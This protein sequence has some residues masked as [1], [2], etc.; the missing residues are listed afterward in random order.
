MVDWFN[1]IIIHYLLLFYPFLYLR[2]N[3]S[4]SILT[5]FT[6][7]NGILKRKNLK[8]P[9]K[10]YFK[11]LILIFFYFGLSLF[12]IFIVFSVL[13]LLLFLHQHSSVLLKY[14]FCARVIINSLFNI[15]AFYKQIIELR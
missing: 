7:L 1:S 12:A 10:F 4:I 5:N 14:L 9:L 8:I 13:D 15:Y 11:V 2:G 6:S 3:L